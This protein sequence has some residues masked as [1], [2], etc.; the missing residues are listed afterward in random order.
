MSLIG[1]RKFGR[2]TALVGTLKAQISNVLY[3]VRLE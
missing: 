1:K 3:A 2:P